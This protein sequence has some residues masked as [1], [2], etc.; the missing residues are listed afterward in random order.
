MTLGLDAGETHEAGAWRLQAER[1]GGEAD[2]AKNR[3]TQLDAEVARLQVANETLDAEVRGLQAKWAEYEG[4]ADAAQNRIAQL[5]TD[6]VRLQRVSDA[7]GSEGMRL[8]AEGA[9]HEETRG[10]EAQRAAATELGAEAGSVSREGGAGAAQD[11]A[12]R[13]DAALTTERQVNSDTQPLA[14]EL[15]RTARN[16]SGV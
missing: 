10:G 3:I 14:A 2:A 9:E 15:A 13:G 4:K 7:L 11:E 6:V 8:Q 16:R 12:I 1:A 5:E